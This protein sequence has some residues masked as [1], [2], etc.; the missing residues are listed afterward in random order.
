MNLLKQSWDVFYLTVRKVISADTSI[1]TMMLSSTDEIQEAISNTINSLDPSYSC[2]MKKHISSHQ[3][4]QGLKN[5]NY[6]RKRVHMAAFHFFEIKLLRNGELTEKILAKKAELEEKVAHELSDASTSFLQSIEGSVDIPV[7]PSEEILLRLLTVQTDVI[8]LVEYIKHGIDIQSFSLTVLE[9][10]EHLSNAIDKDIDKI[11]SDYLHVAID[12]KGATG[13]E[14]T[15]FADRQGVYLY[16]M[17]REALWLALQDTSHNMTDKFYYYVENFE[18]HHWLLL[19]GGWEKEFNVTLSS[20]TDACILTEMAFVLEYFQHYRKTMIQ[21]FTYE[22]F[23]RLQNGYVESEAI[24][25]TLLEAM[26]AFQAAWTDYRP[27]DAL[28]KQALLIAYHFSNP[29]AAGAKDLLERAGGAEEYHAVHGK[30]H[31]HFRDILYH[32]NFYDIF[33]FDLQGNCIYSVFKEL[34]FANNF[35]KDGTGPY[36]DSGLGDAFAA[37]LNAPAE[38]HVTPWAPYR[39]SGGQLASFLCTGVSEGAVLIGVFCAQMPS[40]TQPVTVTTMEE[41]LHLAVHSMST[42]TS[43]FEHPVSCTPDVSMAYW[44]LLL[45]NMGSL[46]SKSYWMETEFLLLNSG[47]SHHWLEQAALGL[48]A[49]KANLLASVTWELSN[50]IHDFTFA[51]E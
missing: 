50:A 15:Y 27:T 11:A 48:E 45:A 9:T 22:D 47:Y 37:A 30:Y 35:A 18:Q 25:S 19:E 51:W 46:E 3:F 24:S 16:E 44:E 2:D 40:E 4:L 39:P 6:V 14:D 5:L 32:R 8:S 36:R 34:D 21:L 33:F 10:V 23:Q 26:K 49:Q 28:R 31:K 1:S 12:G 13:I 43:H 29:N 17:I 7:A 38:I 41:S 42:A 20:T